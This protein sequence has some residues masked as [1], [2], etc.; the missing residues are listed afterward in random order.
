MNYKFIDEPIA[1][2]GAQ[3]TSHYA[4]TQFG[5]LGDSIIAFC[6]ACDI[7]PQFMVDIEDVRDKSEIYAESMLH[8]IIEHHVSSIDTIVLRQ[9][10]F[11]S[12]VQDEINRHLG[13]LIVERKG[14]DL[15]EGGAKLSISVA[16]V[17]P[18]TSL[19]H[20]GINISSQHTP[21]KTKGLEDYHIIPREF[22]LT[23]MTKYVGEYECCERAI[24]KVKWVR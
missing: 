5:L 18:M 21:V 1:Y 15:F 17:T 4:Y 16:T 20:F 7:Q 12:L 24:H 3:L 19:I 13:G 2:T 10:L 14:S 11:S 9:I 6:G 22:A 8:F 23:L